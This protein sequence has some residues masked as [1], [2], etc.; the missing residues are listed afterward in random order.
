MPRSPAPPPTQ[1]PRDWKDG[2]RLRALALPAQGWAGSRSADALG[3]S[4]GAVSQWL[5]IARERGREGLRTRP[6]GRKARKL[7]PAQ[8]AARPA[9]LATGAEADGFIGAV[10]TTARVAAVI[11]REFG[12]RHHPAHVSRRLQ[13]LRWTPPK[14]VKRSINRD[15]AAV[16]AF[17]GER[18]PALRAT[19]RRSSAR[20]SL[21]TNPV[22]IRCRG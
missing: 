8:R 3:V 2:R 5:T 17:R 4:R 6:R 21:S 16:A 11:R 22:A 18:A 13:H 1:P 19:P 7:T 14:P 12:G 15:A 20:S 9:V 10:W